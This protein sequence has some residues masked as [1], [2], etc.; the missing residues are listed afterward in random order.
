MSLSN[1]EDG[2]VTNVTSS[3]SS[4]NEHAPY[5]IPQ[6]R[7]IQNKK[8]SYQNIMTMNGFV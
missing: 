4:E 3:S 7:K 1:S 8:K 2:W 5:N 6:K